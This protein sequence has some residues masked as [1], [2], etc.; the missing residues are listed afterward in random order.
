MPY[1]DVPAF[2]K[3][4]ATVDGIGARALEFCV[5]TAV[6]SG[7][8]FGARWDE[9][10][11][12]DA[13][14]TIPAGRMKAG[15]EHIIPLSSAALAVLEKLGVARNDEFVF[16]GASGKKPLSNMAMTAV[17]RRMDLGEFTVHGFRSAFRDWA[18]DQTSFPREVAEAALAHAVGDQTERAY[19]R[20]DALDK[21]R[22]LMDAWASYLC[23]VA[24]GVVVLAD[25]RAG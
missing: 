12:D 14:W 17:M 4:L 25:R 11:L 19:R 5:L 8:A 2:M 16:P 6:R 9:I 3:R 23:P 13:I 20:G 22:K 1:G 15:R 18:G 10:G 7:E 24:D 21:R